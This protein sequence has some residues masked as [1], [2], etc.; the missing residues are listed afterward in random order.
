[1]SAESTPAALLMPVVIFGSWQAFV[2]P[3]CIAV[4]GARKATAHPEQPLPPGES[5]NFFAAQVRQRLKIWKGVW[6]IALAMAAAMG[7]YLGCKYK[8]PTVLILVCCILDPA[9]FLIMWLWAAVACLIFSGPVKRLW[10]VIALASAFSIFAT[11]GLGLVVVMGLPALGLP[12]DLVEYQY[13]DATNETHFIALGLFYVLL[14]TWA[15]FHW[16]VRRAKAKGD[17]WFRF[18]PQ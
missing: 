2:V 1:M 4:C 12:R 8:F 14:I 3:F 17:E 10:C 16:V 9:I 6:A 7:F 11:V 15:L 5:W 18:T 13:R